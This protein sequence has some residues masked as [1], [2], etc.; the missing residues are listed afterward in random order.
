MTYNNCLRLIGIKVRKG[1]DTPEWKNS[2][3]DKLD[4]FL[5]NNRL[6]NDQYNELVGML[7]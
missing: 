3:K 6:T 1:E 4:I 5:L 2:M 7:K